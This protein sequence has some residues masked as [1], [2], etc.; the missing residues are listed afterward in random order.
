VT[1]SVASNGNGKFWHRYKAG[2]EVSN[3]KVGV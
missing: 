1:E 2:A 3:E